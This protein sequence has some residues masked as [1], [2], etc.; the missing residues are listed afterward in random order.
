MN[1]SSKA[2]T[3]RQAG[4]E[5]MR[6]ELKDLIDAALIPIETELGNLPD[7]Q[8]LDNLINTVS[9]T[10]SSKFDSK[11]PQQEERIKAF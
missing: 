9:K 10:L 7:K 3:R 11:L 4:M 1:Q 8:F 6:D 5:E 2:K